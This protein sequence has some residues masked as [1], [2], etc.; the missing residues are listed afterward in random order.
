MITKTLTWLMAIFISR[1]S[2]IQAQQPGS[3]AWLAYLGV[4]SPAANPGRREA[5]LKALRDHGYVEGKNLAIDYR[6]AEGNAE[7]I[8]EQAAQ[9]V[10]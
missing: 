5:F 9:L 8:Q 4:G 7:L 6:W 3:M 1:W 2:C 10:V